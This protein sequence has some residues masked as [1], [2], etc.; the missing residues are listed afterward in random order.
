MFFQNTNKTIGGVS[1]LHSLPVLNSFFSLLIICHHSY[2]QNIEFVGS[3]NPKDYGV[4]IA[5]ERYFNTVS[6]CAVPIF[7]FCLHSCFTE[8]LMAV[9]RNIYQK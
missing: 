8:H 2:N 4:I 6:E 7:S 5:I 9:R 3:Y 1:L